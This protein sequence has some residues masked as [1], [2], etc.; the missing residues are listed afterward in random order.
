LCKNLFFVCSFIT[1]QV[2]SFRL[3][4]WSD[5]ELAVMKRLGNTRTSRQLL[6][7][8]PARVERPGPD[9]AV[10]V[11]ESFLQAKY[12]RKEMLP[13]LPEEE[14]L[15]RDEVLGEEE[16]SVRREKCLERALLDRVEAGNLPAALHALL[17]G[18]AAS[19]R[20]LVLAARAG[21]LAVAELLLLHGAD[22]KQVLVVSRF[23][24]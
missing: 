3:D 23:V 15:E 19:P 18:A 17:R 6:E 9:S 5:G 12:V 14:E 1:W 11:R 24:P 4:S 22:V 10:S 2:R 21:D 7:A 13:P 16:K 8:L 20:A